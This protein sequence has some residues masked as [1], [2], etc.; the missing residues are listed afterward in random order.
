M[1]RQNGFTVIELI[2]VTL[3]LIVASVVFLHQKHNLEASARDDKRKTDINT[4]Y[5]NL[6]KVYFAQHKSYPRELNEGTLPAVQ[7]DTFK[8]P[9]GTLIN[10]TKEPSL[11]NPQGRD[12]NYR[13]EAKGCNQA[14][15]KCTSYELHTWLELESDYTKKSAAQQ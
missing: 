9:Y 4:L 7:P 10:T 12:S 5:H 1:K 6:E 2:V 3:L 11:T 13:Y 8:D 15:G 14:T